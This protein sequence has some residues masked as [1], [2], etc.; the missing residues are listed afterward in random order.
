MK[1]PA[2]LAL[3][4]V[5]TLL[6]PACVTTTTSTRTWGD[7]YGGGGGDWVR[8]GRVESI[9]EVVQKQQGNPGA[10][11]V[12]GAVIGG[13]LGSALGGHTHYDRY[14]YAHTHA[15]AGGAVVGAVGGAM[16][17]AAASQGSNAEYRSYEVFV[18]YEDGGVER[19]VYQGYAPFRVGDAVA[20]TANGLARE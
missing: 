9:R 13:L 19:H 14:G 18:R 8:Y 2:L 12:A 3:A 6:L 4:L 20:L 15:S 11:A 10:G 1:K 7:P 17:G 16:I 5:P